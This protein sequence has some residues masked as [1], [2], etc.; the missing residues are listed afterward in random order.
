MGVVSASLPVQLDNEVP[1]WG[2]PYHQLSFPLEAVHA[3][4]VL[5]PLNY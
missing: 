3:C 4:S 5:V 1:V 2:I